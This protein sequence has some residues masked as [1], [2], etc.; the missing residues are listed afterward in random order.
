VRPAL[1]RRRA[2]RRQDVAKH[3]TTGWII[4][5]SRGGTAASCDATL[6]CEEPAHLETTTDCW[7]RHGSRAG[8]RTENRTRSF[9]VGCSI[10]SSTAWSATLW[11][12]EAPDAPYLRSPTSGVP[13]VA[14]RRAAG[15]GARSPARNS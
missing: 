6:T 9:R 3:E 7:N 5:G 8:G 1:R 4:V 12:G 15:A 10:S 13:S 11:S 14:A 2:K